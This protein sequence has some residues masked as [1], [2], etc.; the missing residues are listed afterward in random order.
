[1]QKRL[2]PIELELICVLKPCYTG[3]FQRICSKVRSTAF[4]PFTDAKDERIPDNGKHLP[5]YLNTDATDKL[6]FHVGDFRFRICEDVF[7]RFI[8]PRWRSIGTDFRC[9]QFYKLIDGKGN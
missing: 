7:Q 1:M 9:L 6:I 5:K 4:T 3:S 2:F 8:V